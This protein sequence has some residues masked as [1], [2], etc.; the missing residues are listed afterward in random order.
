MT[1]TTPEALRALRHDP[2]CPQPGAKTKREPSGRVYSRCVACSAFLW[3]DRPA[4]APPPPTPGPDTESP[5]RC[6][7]HLEQPVTWRGTGCAK[8]PRPEGDR[9]QPAEHDGR[10]AT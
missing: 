8:C 4:A 3:H 6:R 5:Y 2:Q 10:R 9:P 7:V 1:M